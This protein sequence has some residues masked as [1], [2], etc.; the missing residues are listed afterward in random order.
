[1]I[2]GS[3]K[4]DDL[5]DG[6]GSSCLSGA[7]ADIRILYVIRAA[8]KVISSEKKRSPQPIFCFSL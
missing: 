2:I 1:L 6:P 8:E 5:D 7:F 3:T 4:S